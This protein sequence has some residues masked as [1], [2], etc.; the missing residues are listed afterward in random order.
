MRI[1]SVFVV[2]CVLVVAVAL[3]GTV[4]YVHGSIS[5]RR[6]EQVKTCERGNLVRHNLN[7]V[8]ES[9]GLGLPVLKI[10]DCNTI[11]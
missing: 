4:W 9:L 6:D 5:D 3:S 1:L 7:A 8:V 2:G 11:G 10:V